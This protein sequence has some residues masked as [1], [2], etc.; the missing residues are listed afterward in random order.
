MD[1]DLRNGL[2]SALTLQF[3]RYLRDSWMA[4]SANRLIVVTWVD[5]FKRPVDRIPSDP[6]ATIRKEF[7]EWPWNTV[8]DYIQFV[9]KTDLEWDERSQFVSACNSVLTKELSGYR[10][11]E[12]DLIPIGTE[13]ELAA[14]EQARRDANPYSPVRKHLEQAASLLADRQQPDFRN[15]IKEAISAVEA[16]CGIVAGGKGTL[17]DCLKAMGKG[18]KLHPALGGAFDKLYGWTNDAQGIRHALQDEPNLDLDDARFML[19]ACSAF[20]SYLLAKVG[21]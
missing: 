18:G 10:F 12:Y 19:V 11:V 13:E 1:D 8:Y 5:F 6:V 2:W 9:A 21:T 14:I 7:F 20:V 17:G 4:G 15:S 3:W 16:A